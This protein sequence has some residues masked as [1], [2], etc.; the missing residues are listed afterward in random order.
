MTSDMWRN[1]RSHLVISSDLFSTSVSGIMASKSKTAD[2]VCPLSLC[3]S[4]TTLWA[5][6][7]TH[8]DGGSYALSLLL[9]LAFGICYTHIIPRPGGFV[10]RQFHSSLIW[11]CASAMFFSVMAK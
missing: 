6:I 9:P 4:Q 10:N 8:Q 3:Q 11:S 5:D 7:G 2:L 1:S